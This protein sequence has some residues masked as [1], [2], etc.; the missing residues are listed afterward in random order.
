MN[1]G[2]LIRIGPEGDALDNLIGRIVKVHA[3]KLHGHTEYY[4]LEILTGEFEGEISSDWDPIDLRPLSAL[5]LLA[6]EA[7][8]TE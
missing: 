2:D 8:E 4:D 3:G 7:K 5:E 6:R 1:V